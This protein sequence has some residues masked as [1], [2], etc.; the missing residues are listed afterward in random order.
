LYSAFKKYDPK[1]GN[2]FPRYD[3]NI[4]GAISWILDNT[5][6]TDAFVA[7]TAEN[8]DLALLMEHRPVY[9]GYIGHVSHLGLNWRE[10]Y[11]RSLQLFKANQPINE[12]KYLFWGP[13]E[14]RYFGEPAFP[15]EQLYRD[16]NVV[17]YKQGE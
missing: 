14:R 16:N 4:D 9:L 11:N 13:V 10:R 15:F 7:L 12:V 1:I 2:Y 6:R 3:R 8:S 5:E 17:I